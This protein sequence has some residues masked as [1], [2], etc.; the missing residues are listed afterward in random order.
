[1]HGVQGVASSNLVIPTN[2]KSPHD[3]VGFYFSARFQASLKVKGGKIK[4]GAI[5]RL[6]WLRPTP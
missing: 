3:S 1:M 5:A 2:H 6:L 4:T